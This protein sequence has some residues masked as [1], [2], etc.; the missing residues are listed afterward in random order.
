MVKGVYQYLPGNGE[1]PLEEFKMRPAALESCLIHIW[2][3]GYMTGKRYKERLD[4][5]YG[6][7]RIEDTR[8]RISINLTIW[9]KSW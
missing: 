9:L 3:K 8:G 7:V 1:I 5:G 2:T 6:T 4:Y